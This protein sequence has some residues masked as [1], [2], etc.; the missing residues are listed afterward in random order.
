MTPNITIALRS[1]VFDCPKPEDLGR[2]YAALMGARLAVVDAAWGVVRFD[3]SSFKLAFQRV[4]QYVQ[5]QWP[6]GSPQQLHLDL[7]V[8]DLAVA[9]LSAVALGA[10]VLSERIDEDNSVFMVH[11]DQDDHPFCLCQETEG[12]ID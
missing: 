10:I 6:D 2:F 4:E 3:D 5:P 1:V 8:S 11:A 9:S 7:T 12:I